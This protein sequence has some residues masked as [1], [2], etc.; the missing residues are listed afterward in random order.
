[1]SEQWKLYRLYK[2]GKGNLAAYP[3]PSAPHINYG[4]ANHAL[5]IDSDEIMHFI[6]WLDGK[7]VDAT[8]PVP[9]ESWHLQVPRAQL[10]ALAKKIERKRKGK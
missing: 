6:N 10:L 9:G 8:R 2:A 7:G 4:R 5:D 3:T 1:M